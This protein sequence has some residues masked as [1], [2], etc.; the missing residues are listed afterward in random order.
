MQ[1]RERGVH[2]GS[3]DERHEDGVSVAVDG[4][5]GGE[6][7]RVEGLHEGVFFGG[8]DSREV[9]PVV[10][11]PAF[12]VISVVLDG[13]EGLPAESGELEDHLVVFVVFAQEDVWSAQ[14]TGLF[15]DADLVHDF[16]D[17]A[18]LEHGVDGQEVVAEVVEFVAVIWVSGWYS[19]CCSGRRACV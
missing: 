15:A 13:L 11:R 5:R 19:S 7:C 4:S 17:G 6:A 12:E 16:G 18:A 8:R 2:G 10:L 14:S 3:V 1:L 9:E